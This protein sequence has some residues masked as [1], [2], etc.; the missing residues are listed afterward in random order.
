VGHTGRRRFLFAAIGAPIFL[1]APVDA[2]DSFARLI[3]ADVRAYAEVRGLAR[4][5]ERLGEGGTWTVWSQVV[6]G[7]TSQPTITVEWGQRVGRILNMTLAEAVRSLFGQQVALAAPSYDELAQGVVLARAP[8][9]KVI[10][11]LIARNQAQQQPSVGT[12]SRY[13]LKEGLSLAVQGD[14]V[15]LGQ[16]G[17]KADLFERT[18]ALLSGQQGATLASAPAFVEQA[19]RLPPGGQGL[20]YLDLA[21]TGA[22]TTSSGSQPSSDSTPSSRSPWLNMKRLVLGLYDRAGGIDLEVRGLLDQPMP[23]VGSKDLSIDSIGRLPRSTLLVWAQTLDLAGLYRQVM[24]DRDPQERI[25]RFNLEVIQALL[26]PAD[27]EK[28]LLAKLGPQA[29]VVL[30]RVPTAQS[31]PADSY[32]LPLLSVMIEAREG[33]VNAAMLQRLGERFLGWMKVEFARA[34]QNLD[35]SIDQTPYRQTVIY[36]IPL[37]TLFKGNTLCPY[38]TTLELCWAGVKGW[39]I[40]SSHSDHVRQIIDAREAP[41]AETLADTA[42]FKSLGHHQEASSLLLMQP[43][44]TASMLQSWLDY[45]AKHA[46][47]V[48]E[49][50]WWKRMVVRGLGRRVELGIII[51]G[52][53]EPGRV[54]VGSPVL[55]EMP[56]AG[57]LMPGDKICAVDGKNL[58]EDRPEDDLRDLVALRPN[59]EVVLRVERGGKLLDVRI[60]LSTQQPLPFAADWDPI[61]S[62]R[63]LISLG[64]SLDAAGYVGANSTKDTH[65]DGTLVLRLNHATSQPTSR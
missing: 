24:S 22:A 25:I 30:G 54:I 63:Y 60:P 65:F 58:S 18:V 26:R 32:D 45:C 23:R 16:H 64:Q 31:R 53:A 17:G 19:N 37:G 28:D 15:V 27:L 7:Q 57:R 47:R 21:A 2:D 9:P 13:A 35:L 6:A 34:K 11:E 36:R 59:A 50:L 39:L 56:A 62:I 38:L 51:K 5:G 8:D 46:P 20:L 14:V 43:A 52:G 48:L 10:S 61:R 12:V 33:E 44:A 42:A 41:P 40:V 4:I 3:P 1:C 55:P 29:M 49:P